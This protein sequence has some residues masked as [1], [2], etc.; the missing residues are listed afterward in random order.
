MNWSQFVTGSK[1]L[2]TQTNPY[3]YTE[4]GVL[5]LANVLK[6]TLATQFSIRLVK[7]FV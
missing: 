5:M 2:N 6:S 3:A 7:A 4:H 1:V